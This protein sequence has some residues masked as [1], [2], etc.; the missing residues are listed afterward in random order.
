MRRL[1]IL[2]LVCAL[3]AVVVQQC[4]ADLKELYRSPVGS[5]RSIAANG[6]DGS[7]WLSTLGRVVHMSA[8]GA[9]LSSTGEFGCA[10]PSVDQTDGSCWVADIPGKR[11]THLAQDGT[12][13]WASAD[14]ERPLAVSVDSSDGSCWLATANEIVL[15][16]RDG[17]EQW[18]RTFE[19]VNG[20]LEP[21]PERGVCWVIVD[22]Q[23]ALLSKTGTELW[24]GEA[25]GDCSELAL[26]PVDGSCWLLNAAAVDG[27][28]ELVRFSMGGD[29]IAAV[30][31]PRCSDLIGVDPANE[32]LWVTDGESRQIV[33]FSV[34]GAE[35]GR[36]GGRPTYCPPHGA[37][38]PADGSLLVTE[39]GGNAVVQ[40]SR[41]GTEEW[42]VHNHSVNGTSVDPRDGSCWVADGGHWRPETGDMVGGAA[43]KFD[44]NGMELLEVA[45]VSQ[46]Q[47]VAVDPA[48]GSCWI[49]DYGAG[50]VI[51]V[52]AEGAE[53]WRG[54]G[55]LNPASLSV[56]AS[57]GSCWVADRGLYDGTVQ[58]FVGS[59]L[60]HL[61]SDGTEVWRS[62]NFASVRAVAVDPND[63]SCWVADAAEP[64][65]G[66]GALIHLSANGTEIWREVY[67]DQPWFVSVNPVDGSVWVS[68]QSR[69]AHIAADGS[70]VF[71][72]DVNM[73]CVIRLAVDPRDGSCWAVGVGP[74]YPAVCEKADPSTSI[75]HLAA[76]GAELWQGTEFECATEISVNA[77]DGTLWLSDYGQLVHLK[78]SRF[79]DVPFA[80]WAYNE[81]EACAAAGIVQGYP[82][83]TYRPE[84]PVSR[85]QMAVYI[86][87]AIAG[88]EAAVPTSPATASFPDV[89]TSYWAFKHIEYARA[90]DIVQ[91]YPDGRYRPGVELDR[92][93]MAVFIAR[94]IVTP[95][96]DAGL[97]GYAPPDTPT[98]PDV[99]TRH[100]AYGY[101]EYISQGSVAVTHGYPDGLYWPGWTCTRDQMAVYVALGFK[102]E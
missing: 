27:S 61:R 44:G 12:V 99:D 41:E 28:G 82:G 88:G 89:P 46:P 94:A 29:R 65:G 52:S 86:A 60:V 102:L 97:A 10:L 64:L 7:W 20:P 72:R 69:V 22:R 49:G 67:A 55:F 48:D 56:N 100:W 33:Q 32:T 11:L 57:D 58:G 16:A 40:L 13:M 73:Q 4:R 71:A 1:R 23:L 35:L 18:R 85:D 37:I 42:H 8:D 36:I 34:S 75:L 63:G 21:D 5:V 78:S 30:V 39:I 91:G 95:H 76:D 17:T 79:S 43:V 9:V 59:A 84:T 31:S 74:D 62:G 15:L 87:R 51:H 38:N 50:E 45:G 101:I 93:Q 6:S 96:G 90:E 80:H 92:G 24:R 25:V 83:G 3:C 14:L 54:G 98:Y 2:L 53:L 70:L 19:R 68:L 77:A 81:V 66:G 47:E 26:D